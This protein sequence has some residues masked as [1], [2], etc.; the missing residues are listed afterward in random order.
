MTRTRND[1]A[2]KTASLPTDF[3]ERRALG[4]G[5]RVVAGVDEAGRGPLAGPVVAAAVILGA[6]PAPDGIDDS[7]N[8]SAAERER[9]C[10]EI[11]RW[12]TVSVVV[13]SAARID[14]INILQ[15]SLWAMRRA[16]SALAE[17]PDHVLIDGRDVPAGLCCEG[18]AL[19]GGD[20]LSLSVAAA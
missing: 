16:V 15:A 9:L 8:V 4:N 7:K 18:E 19:I 20:G 12:G 2:V 1:S 5:A 14:A 6:G 10:G 3:Y 17:R 13:A 11:L